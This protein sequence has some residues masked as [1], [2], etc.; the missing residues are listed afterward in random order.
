MPFSLII[1]CFAL[2]FLVYGEERKIICFD[3]TVFLC[4]LHESVKMCCLLF[5]FLLV[6]VFCFDFLGSIADWGGSY[7]LIDLFLEGSTMVAGGGTSTSRDCTDASDSSRFFQSFSNA[8]W[9]AI[10][11]GSSV[12]ASGPCPL[13]CPLCGVFFFF[14]LL[15]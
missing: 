15:F 3:T 7:A 11:N 2:F 12:H 10:V 4:F 14:Y 8:L 6:G 9:V 1:Y 13:A 5:L